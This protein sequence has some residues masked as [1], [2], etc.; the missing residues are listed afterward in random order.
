MSKEVVSLGV[1]LLGVGYFF[2][3]FEYKNLFILYLHEK[4]NDYTV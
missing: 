4:K 3:N 1:I 2:Y